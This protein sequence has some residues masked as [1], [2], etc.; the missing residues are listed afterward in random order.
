VTAR[1]I[2]DNSD[3]SLSEEKPILILWLHVL[4]LFEASQAL[5]PLR[6]TTTCRYL[7]AFF[8]L[9]SLL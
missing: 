1:D 6:G 3:N 9:L 5:S 4:Q 7:A 2:K 8:I